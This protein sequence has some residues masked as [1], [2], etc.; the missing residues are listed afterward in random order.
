MKFRIYRYNPETD[1]QP[2]MQ[3]Y[4]LDIEA[5]DKML[6]DALILIKELDDR[7]AVDGARM[8]LMEQAVCGE[9]QCTQ[10]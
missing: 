2:T 6:L 8:D 10:H 7:R 3:D 1:V 5:G 4:E 9:V